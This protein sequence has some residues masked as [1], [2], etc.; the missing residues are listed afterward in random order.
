MDATTD[1]C[2]ASNTGT[3]GRL[4][5]RGRGGYKV[6]V[7]E[8]PHARDGSRASWIVLDPNERVVELANSELLAVAKMQALI[9]SELGASIAGKR[10]PRR[11][12]KRGA[13]DAT[14]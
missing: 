5:K 4:V 3:M 14:E 13:S 12:D 11:R 8:S 9:L 10:T 6:C 1:A 2:D 7:V